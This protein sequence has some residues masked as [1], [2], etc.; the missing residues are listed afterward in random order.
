MNESRRLMNGKRQSLYTIY[1]MLACV[2]LTVCKFEEGIISLI[3]HLF[4]RNIAVYL[5]HKFIYQHFYIS[6]FSIS[7]YSAHFQI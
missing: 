1:I 6:D 5:Q 2:F 4:Q 3:C 7:T